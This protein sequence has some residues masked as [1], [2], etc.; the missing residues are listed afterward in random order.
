MR[1]FDWLDL[2]MLM[3]QDGGTGGEGAGGGEGGG[4]AGGSGDAGGGEGGGDG[5]DGGQGGDSGGGDGDAGDAGGSLLGD[6]VGGDK[7]GESGDGGGEGKPDG[8]TGAPES[9]ET[10]TVPEGWSLDEAHLEI[11]A[12]IFKE[13]G[14]SQEMAQKA[15]DLQ[16]AIVKKQA[17]DWSA[18]T[19]EWASEVKTDKTYGGEHLQGNLQAIGELIQRA[20]S[21]ED[22]KDIREFFDSTGY[23][24]Y[25]PLF[26]LLS[27]IARATGEDSFEGPGQ[28]GESPADSEQAFLDDMYPSMKKQAG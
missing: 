2:L 9:Y 12:P 21:P 7:G 15:V 18:T 19:A 22:A 5:G 14:L 4:D 20:A 17:E 16:V 24:N 11:A 25:P 6:A 10:F 26:R 8:G 23:G 27:R 13:M 1:I 3:N 28:R